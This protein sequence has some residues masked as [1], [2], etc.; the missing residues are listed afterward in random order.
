MH[1][2]GNSWKKGK[3]QKNE[4]KSATCATCLKHPTDLVGFAVISGSFQAM[5]PGKNHIDMDWASTLGLKIQTLKSLAIV[6]SLVAQVCMVAKV[7]GNP[8]DSDLS[9]LPKVRSDHST[10]GSCKAK[11][12]KVL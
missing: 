1:P 6:F 7:L 9:W 8:A 11:T 2:W 4:R 12:C 5:F 10:G 3:G